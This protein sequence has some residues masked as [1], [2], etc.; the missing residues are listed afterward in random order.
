MIAFSLGVSGTHPTAAISG[1]LPEVAGCIRRTGVPPAY[2]T[3][4]QVAC[5]STPVHAPLPLPTPTPTPVSRL[6]H[7]RCRRRRLC[8]ARRPAAPADSHQPTRP[9]QRAAGADSEPH[10]G[11]VRCG[12]RRAAVVPGVSRAAQRFVHRAQQVAGI[13][14]CP[15]RPVPT[16]V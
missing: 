9:E 14:I 1:N 3:P 11:G 10:A 12:R 8:L 16:K 6:P 13:L 5:G 4:A 2:L 7:L 15:G